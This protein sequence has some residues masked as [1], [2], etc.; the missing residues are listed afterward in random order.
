[1]K[2]FIVA[3]VVFVLMAW[4][5]KVSALWSAIIAGAIAWWIWSRAKKDEAASTDEG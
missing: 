5:L 1:M 2:P 3:A 4:V